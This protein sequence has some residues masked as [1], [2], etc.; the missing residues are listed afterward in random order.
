MFLIKGNCSSPPVHCSKYWRSSHS[1]PLVFFQS[2][3][4]RIAVASRIFSFWALQH[5]ASLGFFGA[6]VHKLFAI[7]DAETPEYV[8]A[9]CHSSH[10]PKSKNMVLKTF[11]KQ[12][13]YSSQVNKTFENENKNRWTQIPVSP[14]SPNLHVFPDHSEARIHCGRGIALATLTLIRAAPLPQLSSR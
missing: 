7:M 2:P 6:Y 14:P 8:K 1:L 3:G 4:F 11:P 5:C 10:N 9:N 12:N 13:G